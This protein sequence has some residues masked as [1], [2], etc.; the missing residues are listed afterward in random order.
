MATKS[1]PSR[2]PNFLLDH[3]GAFAAVFAIAVAGAFCGMLYT[4]VKDAQAHKHGGEHGAS[5][6]DH[7]AA[8]AAPHGSA[9]PAKH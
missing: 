9:A 5:S 3:P 7:G 4:V 2:E 1:T 6:A 8:T